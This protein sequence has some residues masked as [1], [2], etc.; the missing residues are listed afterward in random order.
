MN[1]WLLKNR[2]D[3]ASWKNADDHIRRPTAKLDEVGCPSVY[4]VIIC[5]HWYCLH[6]DF[7]PDALAYTFVSPR[8][9]EY[10]VPESPL[11]RGACLENFPI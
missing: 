8:D 2:E 11:T 9:F 6:N 3:F 7:A 1:R 4:P 10:H 5:W